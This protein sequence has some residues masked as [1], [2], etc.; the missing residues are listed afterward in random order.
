MCWESLN[1]VSGLI[2]LKMKQSWFEIIY[3]HVSLSKK[4]HIL[5]TLFEQKKIFLFKNSLSKDHHKDETLIKVYIK[6]S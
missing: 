5:C 3:G 1:L 6:D 4:I 2:F